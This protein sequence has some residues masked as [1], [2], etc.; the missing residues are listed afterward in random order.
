M[1]SVSWRGGAVS[2]PKLGD[3]TLLTP[4]FFQGLFYRQ[5][6]LKINLNQALLSLKNLHV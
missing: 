4:L 2:E 1:L 6:T 3:G 5:Q